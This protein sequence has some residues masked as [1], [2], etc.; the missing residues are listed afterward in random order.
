M[1]CF[2]K[3]QN[4][5][6]KIS[7]PLQKEKLSFLVF[8]LRNTFFRREVTHI[9]RQKDI[10]TYRLNRPRDRFIKHVPFLIIF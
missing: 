8:N 4:I 9:N 1:D 10:A 7:Q 6:L 5:L 2:K 3:P